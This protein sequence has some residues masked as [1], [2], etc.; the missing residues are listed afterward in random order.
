MLQKAPE[1]NRP[2]QALIFEYDMALA[3]AESDGGLV[4][5]LD[6]APPQPRVAH[7][8]AN[9]TCVEQTTKTCG[10]FRCAFCAASLF[11]RAACLRG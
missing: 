11:P 7:A 4:P 9:G 6:G 3:K 2:C 5:G 8:S 1:S 10:F